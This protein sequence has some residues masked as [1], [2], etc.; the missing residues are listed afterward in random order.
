[1][2]SNNTNSLSNPKTEENFS[3]NNLE[4]PVTCDYK[5]NIN[6]DC[7]L[8]K[9]LEMDVPSILKDLESYEI[10]GWRE[11]GIKISDYFNYGKNYKINY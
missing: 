1:M 5:L 7:F 8:S 3:V 4:D 6:T 10:K 11:P 9:Y 2:E